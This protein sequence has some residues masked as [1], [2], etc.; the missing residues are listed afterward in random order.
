M[1]KLYPEKLGTDAL[2]AKFKKDLREEWADL[3]EDK[4]YAGIW[5]DICA[6]KPHE[7]EEKQ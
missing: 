1:S 4:R 7:S 3:D 6:Q 2:V 5:W